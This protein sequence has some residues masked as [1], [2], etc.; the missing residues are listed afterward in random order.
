MAFAL[1]IRQRLLFSH[2]FAVVVV[3]GAFGVFVYWMAAQQVAA[4]LRTQQADS[5]A[6]IA[7]SLDPARLAAAV[8]DA[9]VRAAVTMRLQ[10]AARNYSEVGR[11]FIEGPGASLVAESA[12]VPADIDAGTVHA[13][14]AGGA[15][16]VG[17]ELRPGATT[18][19]LYTLRLSAAL[20]FLVCVLAAMLLGR[21][22]AWRL[23]ARITDLIGRCRA[24]ATGEPL[25]SRRPGPR[26]EFDRLT[27]EFDAMAGRLRHAAED[28]ER[29]HAALREANARL[30]SRVR[31]RT[32]AL[33]G[34]TAKLKQEIESRVH[35]EALLAEAAMTDSL[36]GLLNRRAMV[37]MLEQAAAQLRPGEPGLSVIV[38]DID[39]FKNV[40]DRF[41]H[42]AGDR[43]LAAVATR[44]RELA[45][46]P[47][48]V[49]RWGGEEFLILLPGV[50][51]ATACE[52]AEQL[53]HAVTTLR[54]GADKLHVSLSLGVAEL[55]AGGPLDECLRRCD[56]A[57]YKA[58]DLGRN[59]V[60]AA[61][62][63]RF[64]TIS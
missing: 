31:E 43:V 46:D 44:L 18:D 30:E 13:P 37:E 59:A 24:L 28:R 2:L 10:D 40:N 42:D 23:L 57:L 4:R 54:I 9:A 17:V 8:H 19:N 50:R 16:R 1:G 38:A 7:S 62:G 41:G 35:M 48:H 58:K 33:E 56:Q 32:A 55:L 63:G 39:H 64:A 26:D 25:P 36:T 29:A 61:Q 21:H 6:L 53:R 22:L 27:R 51:L 11:I 12:A 45:G 49:A 15:Y 52:R 3:A 47:Q 14:V 60:V 5:A 34:A 20:A